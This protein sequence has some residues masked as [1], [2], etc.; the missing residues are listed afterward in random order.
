[1]LDRDEET[2]FL[3]RNRVAET[4]RRFDATSF[5]ESML[6]LSVPAGQ[7]I[8]MASGLDCHPLAAAVRLSSSTRENRIMPG[9]LK[10][11]IAIIT[12]AGRGIGAQTV[13]RFV[14]ESTD[15]ASFINGAALMVDGGRSVLCHD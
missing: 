10:D 2:R 3:A 5:G 12:G 11:K 15:E 6:R 1:M 4:R 9:R 13:R 8:E 7:R 14:E